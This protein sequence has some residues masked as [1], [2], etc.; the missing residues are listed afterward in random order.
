M[1]E[2]SERIDRIEFIDDE[3]NKDK[4]MFSGY[5]DWS[6]VIINTE[7]SI[8]PDLKKYDFTNEIKNK[9]DV[10]YSKMKYQ[11]RR[12][13]IR[14]QMLFFC[15]YCAHLEL[16]IDI[17]PI[18]LGG[19][20]GLSKGEVQRCE[21]IFSPL[22]TGYKPPT[23]ITSPLGYLPNFCSILSLSNDAVNDITNLGNKILNKDKSLY[24]E[25][26]QTVAAGLLRYYII[27]NG[28]ILNEPQKLTFI[29]GRSNVT[30]DVMYRRISAIDNI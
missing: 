5:N 3:I 8:L 20:F 2:I 22:Q 29:T 21:S 9:A 11:V 25:N 23:K 18:H 28:I 24:Q 1:C 4:R 12:G 26:P 15:I 19:L 17:N 16:N 13:K 10:I 7:K 14:F 6:H 30:I 27:T